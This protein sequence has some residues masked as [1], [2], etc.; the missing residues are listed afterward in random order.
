M[1]RRK[2]NWFIA[3]LKPVSLLTLLFMVFGIVWLRSSVVSLEY[4]LS[5][6]EKKRAELMREKKGLAAEQANLLYIGRLQSVASNGTGFEFPD[7]VRVVY[8]KASG[9]SDIYKAS[10]TVGDKSQ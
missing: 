5:N 3:L 7:R 10:L 6:L 1:R 9:K 2:N 4:S 8:V